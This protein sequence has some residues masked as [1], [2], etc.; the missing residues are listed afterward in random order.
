MDLASLNDLPHHLPGD[1]QGAHV[2]VG[3][4]ISFYKPDYSMGT[5][6]M[7]VKYKG[8]VILGADSRTSSGPYVVNRVSDKITALADNIFVCRSGSAADTQTLADLTRYYLSLHTQELGREPDVK[9]AASILRKVAYQYRD[10][11]T[12]GLIVAGWDAKNGAQVYSIPLGGAVIEQNLAA[13]GSGSTYILGF[14]DNNYKQDMTREECENFVLRAI[15]LAIFRDESSGG[16]VR[17][18]NVDENGNTRRFVAGN[19]LETFF[20]Q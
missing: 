11:L 7:A 19:E 17:L 14:L 3:G 16:I 5:T 18:V 1:A 6:I 15:S 8:G 10:Q 12:A 13:G 20:H 4:D 9:T 2:S